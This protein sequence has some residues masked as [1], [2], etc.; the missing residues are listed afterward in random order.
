MAWAMV[1]KVGRVLSRELV[2]YMAAAM[3]RAMWVTLVEEAKQ[4]E[5]RSRAATERPALLKPCGYT[6]S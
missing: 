3:W 4:A 2:Q 1:H 5:E 6:P